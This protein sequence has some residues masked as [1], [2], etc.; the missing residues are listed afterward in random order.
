MRSDGN[1]KVKLSGMFR[2]FVKIHSQG[3]GPPKSLPF[4]YFDG[5][6]VEARTKGTTG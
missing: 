5:A 6:Y 3:S 1:R 4:E 2:Y